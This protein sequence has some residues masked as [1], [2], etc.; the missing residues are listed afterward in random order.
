MKNTKE[1]YKDKNI[2]IVLLIIFLLTRILF[3][4]SLPIFNDEAT[5]IDWAWRMINIKG[6]FF[7]SVVHYKP[8]LFMWAVGIFRKFISDPLIAGRLI[9]IF[10]GFLSFIGIYKLAFKLFNQKVALF[11]AMFYT[12]IPLFVFYDRQ[13]LMESS[14]TACGIWS[15]YFFLKLIQSQK[16]K[17]AAVLGLTL[18]LGYLVKTNAILFAI[19][20]FTFYLLGYKQSNTKNLLIT[21]GFVFLSCFLLTTS[22]LLLN[23][24][25]WQTL[26][27]NK[28]YIFTFSELIK[29]PFI[30]WF[31]NLKNFTTIT[32]LYL[33]PL[34]ILLS[35]ASIYKSIK[36]KNNFQI[37]SVAYLLVGWFFIIILSRS[38]IPRHVVS[39]LP[40]I[41]IYASNSLVN[42]YEKDKVLLYLIS[43]VIITP[44]LTLSLIQITF[45]QKYFNALDKISHHSM[46]AE[47]ITY[48]SSG[49]GI[50]EVV[51]Y[52]KSE[53]KTKPIIVGVRLDAG[54]PENAIIAYFQGSNNIL[55][56]YLDA[57]MI[58]NF[59]YYD[60][61]N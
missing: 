10:A 38:V 35:A 36:D 8:P 2:L 11:S 52:L 58:K 34:I 43:G 16:L 41:L 40:L 24:I 49:Y 7:H 50:D 22:P 32:L 29:F 5:Y 20:L 19:P 23:S 42:I 46:K 17:Y 56:T 60:C 15:L 4:K 1:S 48:W 44:F 25:F 37:L 26:G 39:Y 31:N 53:A 27:K 9:S 28:D 13:A 61:I 14:V 12:I 57:Q 6:E 30:S 45:P 54:N 47:Y 18:G 59:T 33:N 51:N 21:N 3:L 55:P